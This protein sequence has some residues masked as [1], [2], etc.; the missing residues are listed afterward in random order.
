LKETVGKGAPEALK[1]Y[2]E[3]RNGKLIDE[4]NMNQLGYALI[5]MKRIDDA[6]LLFEQNTVDYPQSWNV[7]DSLAEA[8][9]DKGDKQQ[10]IADYEKSLQLNPGNTNGAEQLKKLKSN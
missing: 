6:I 10:A 7:W 2:K 3:R 9:M 8:Y 4:S 5:G 1:H